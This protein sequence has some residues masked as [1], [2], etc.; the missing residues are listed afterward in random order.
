MDDERDHLA[1]R[2][3]SIGRASRPAVPMSDDHI[4]NAVAKV[5]T[6]VLVREFRENPLDVLPTVEQSTE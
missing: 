6:D 3:V 2:D 1:T 5:L 4:S